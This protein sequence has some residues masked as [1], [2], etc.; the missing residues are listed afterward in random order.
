[1]HPMA[2]KHLN[3]RAVG[4][5]W[6]RSSICWSNRL[7][8]VFLVLNAVNAQ[9]TE[10]SRDSG[11]EEETIAVVSPEEKRQTAY[12]IEEELV[13]SGRQEHIASPRQILDGYNARQM[14]QYYYN[15]RLYKKAY[16][17]LLEAAQEGFKM[18]QARLG[19]LYQQGLGGAERDWRKA[20]G[21]IGVAASPDSHP[22]IRNYWKDMRA[23]IPQEQMEMVEAIVEDYIN[24]F[25][26]DTTGISCDINRRAGSHIARMRCTYD[27][28]LLYRDPGDSLGIPGIQIDSSVGGGGG[29][30]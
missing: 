19:F 7:F 29:G 17:Y 13:V 21:W 14:G 22:E 24:K 20:V 3:I 16:P 18:S 11:L 10:Q 1:M 30:P 23:K 9:E 5:V 27:D 4:S 8:S 28:E 15:L 26:S 25:G 12:A 6:R 2:S